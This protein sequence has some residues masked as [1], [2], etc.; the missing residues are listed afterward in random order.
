V[1]VLIDIDHTISDAFWRD[2]IIGAVP[3]DEYH[4]ESQHDKPFW[5][6][7]D[8]INA[9]WYAG[10]TTIAITGR[11]EKFRKLTNDWFLEYDVNIDELL[12]RPDDNFMK[13][14]DLKKMLIEER[15]PDLDDVSFIIDDNEDSILTFFKMGITTF[16]IRNVSRE[17]DDRIRN[18][19]TDSGGSPPDNEGKK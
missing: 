9:L 16:Q 17:R 12:M 11:N 1:H 3:W 8:L 14:G 2:S 4:E 19:G 6:V 10:Y 18:G 7:I 15:F 5:N 13:N